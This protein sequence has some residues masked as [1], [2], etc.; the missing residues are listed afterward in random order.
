MK[1]KINSINN[2]GNY[3]R[4]Y[5]TLEVLESCDIGRFLLSD[6]TYTNIGQLSN[7]VR[8]ILVPR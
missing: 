5:V 7:K 2:K 1:V 6:S 4:E 3:N 8:Y